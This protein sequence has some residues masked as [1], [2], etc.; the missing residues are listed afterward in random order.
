MSNN[1]QNSEEIQQE[2]NKLAEFLIDVYLDKKNRH[3]VDSV[4]NEE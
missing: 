2:I 1:E 3:L 4:L